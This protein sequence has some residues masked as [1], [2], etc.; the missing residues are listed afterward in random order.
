MPGSHGDSILPPGVKLLARALISAT[1]LGALLW[2]VEWDEW[3]GVR[4]MYDVWGDGEYVW[5]VG[6]YGLVLTN[7]I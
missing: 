7:R 1:L 2:S 5:V 6:N 3:A 4:N